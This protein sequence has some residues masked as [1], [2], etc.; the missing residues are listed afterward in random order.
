MDS[1]ERDVSPFESLVAFAVIFLSA[2]FL[3]AVVG[4]LAR[5]HVE[6]DRETSEWHLKI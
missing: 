3:G 2:V 5:G 6:F 4:W 1:G